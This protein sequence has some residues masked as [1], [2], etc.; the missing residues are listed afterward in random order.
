MS[1]SSL[2]CS[3]PPP[4]RLT[5]LSG[6][7]LTTGCPTHT[8]ADRDMHLGYNPRARV[9]PGVITP[10]EGLHTPLWADPYTGWPPPPTSWPSLD[11]P[12]WPGIT[13]SRDGITWSFDGRGRSA[14]AL[15]QRL[16]L[17]A[18][19]VVVENLFKKG[20][21]PFLKCSPTFRLQWELFR[22]NELECF[23]GML[24]RCFKQELEEVGHSLVIYALD[25]EPRNS[26]LKHLLDCSK[27]E[28]NQPSKPNESFTSVGFA[29]KQNVVHSI[30]PEN[31]ALWTFSLI[32]AFCFFF[33]IVM[34]YEAY[35]HALLRELEKRKQ[36]EEM[37][38]FLPSF[39]QRT[40]QRG[41]SLQ[42]QQQ[43]V[44]SNQQEKQNVEQCPPAVGKQNM[45]T[46]L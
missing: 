26:C 21:L 10:G 40:E 11:W 6:P 30:V 35:R 36:E 39:N 14:F 25:V 37:A 46:I 27:I 13:L 31:H 22:T 15:S 42:L 24:T 9:L 28:T 4:H 34:T 20:T 16:L 29:K 43:Q 41:H 44:P 32:F 5:P 17:G 38:A 8:L 19:V 45:E 33:K 7:T 18:F 1:A 23:E 3:T 2:S 12:P